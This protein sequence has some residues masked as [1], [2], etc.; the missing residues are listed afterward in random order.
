M[1]PI[2]KIMEQIKAGSKDNNTNGYIRNAIGTAQ[3][4]AADYLNAKTGNWSP[5]KA[6]IMLILFCLVTGNVSLYITGRAILSANGPPE[7]FKVQR[8][9]QPSMVIPPDRDRFQQ[10]DTALNQNL[11]N[12]K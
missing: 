11:H 10:A 4:H 8:L 3:R 9:A 5:R 7:K 6:K 1:I 2:K 12:Q